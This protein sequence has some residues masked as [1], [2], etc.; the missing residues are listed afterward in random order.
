ML[1]YKNKWFHRWAAREG[2]G[3]QTLL[4]AVKEWKA[5]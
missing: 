2:L 3:N 1:V 5:V 4:V